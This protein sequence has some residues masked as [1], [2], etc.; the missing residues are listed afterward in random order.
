MTTVTNSNKVKDSCLSAIYEHIRDCSTSWQFDADT[1]AGIC[2]LIDVDDS[3][4]FIKKF[5]NTANVILNVKAGV[6]LSPRD[7]YYLIKSDNLY[8]V[9]IYLNISPTYF[10]FS[11]IMYTFNMCMWLGE[12]DYSWFEYQVLSLDASESFTDKCQDVFNHC[13]GELLSRLKKFYD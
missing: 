11:L 10:V 2:E 9:L 3:I 13:L 7:I 1:L 5:G 12:K 8:E 4:V 6:K